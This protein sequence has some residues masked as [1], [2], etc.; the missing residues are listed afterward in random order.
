MLENRGNTAGLRFARGLGRIEIGEWDESVHGLEAA[1]ARR[2]AQLEE[3][4][5]A[6][7]IAGREPY[8][9]CHKYIFFPPRQRN[10]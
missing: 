1:D 6:R 2:I 8:S 9:Q 5:I 3:S 4:A 10:Q 7:G